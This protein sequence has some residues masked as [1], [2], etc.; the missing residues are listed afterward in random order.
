MKV[1]VQ[2]MQPNTESVLVTEHSLPHGIIFKNTNL[3]NDVNCWHKFIVSILTL[4]NI[5]LLA[6]LQN[7][8][9]LFVD[10]KIDNTP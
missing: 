3:L 9:T 6:N 1:Q 4:L 2:L 10:I 5:Y 7:S 8:K